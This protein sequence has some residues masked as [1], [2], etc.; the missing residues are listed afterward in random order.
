MRFKQ[1]QTGFIIIDADFKPTAPE[2]WAPNSIFISCI[3]WEGKI[4][5]FVTSVDTIYL[6]ESL[7]TMRF[8]IEE[9]IASE[10]FQ[11]LT[12]S[13]AKAD[14]GD[15]FKVIIRFPAPKPCIIEKD[16]KGLHW[17]IIG[18]YVSIH[19]VNSTFQERFV[20]NPSSLLVIHPPPVLC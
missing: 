3:F 11:P 4:E 6:L 7:I 1:S 17:K 20:Y 10:S 12:I 2:E 13:K 14:S 19:L 18:K 9:K 16:V 8:T 5:C 15:F